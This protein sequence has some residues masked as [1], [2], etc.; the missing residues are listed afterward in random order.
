MIYGLEWVSFFLGVKPE[1]FGG[2]KNVK[3]EDPLIDLDRQ[4][5]ILCSPS[6]VSIV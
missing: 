6:L 1:Q 4:A 5:C 2:L 3:W